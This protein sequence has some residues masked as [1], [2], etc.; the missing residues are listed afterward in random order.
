[1]MVGK[2]TKWKAIVIEFE[3][4]ILS[5]SSVFVPHIG[6]PN[7]VLSLDLYDSLLQEFLEGGFVGG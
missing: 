3:F 4:S 6:C 1:M 7:L 2:K 5:Y